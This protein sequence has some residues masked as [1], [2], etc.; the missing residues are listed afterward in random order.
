[1]VRMFSSDGRRSS[2]ADSL[3]PPWNSLPYVRST[4]SVDLLE[5]LGVVRFGLGSFLYRLSL[6]S[7]PS[8]R[9]SADRVDN[10]FVRLP[11]SS[12]GFLDSV[13]MSVPLVRDACGIAVAQRRGVIPSCQAVETWL[14]AIVNTLSRQDG[15]A[16][17]AEMNLPSSGDLSGAAFLQNHAV[18]GYISVAIKGLANVVIRDQDADAAVAQLPDDVWM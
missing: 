2:S 11:S 1:M 12:T 3:A 17:L 4:R 8:T 5:I 7:T 9:G 6:P 15:L 13:S 16:E 14:D 18:V 10:R